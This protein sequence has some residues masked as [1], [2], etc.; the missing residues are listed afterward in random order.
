[1]PVKPCPGIGE[2]KQL[3]PLN[4][5]AC[6][7]HLKHNGWSYN[8]DRAAQRRLRRALLERANGQCEWLDIRTGIRCA[9]TVDLRA[10]HRTPV[11]EG[12]SY[13]PADAVLL[14]RRHDRATDRN[15]R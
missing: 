12:G 5:R 6:P 4:V 2:C 13:D 8:R 10:C 9:T 11:G 7:I 1:M 15:A 14:C 3:I